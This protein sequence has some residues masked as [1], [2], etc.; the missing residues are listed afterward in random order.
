MSKREIRKAVLENNTFICEKDEK[1]LQEKVGAGAEALG[2]T[3]SSWI[4]GFVTAALCPSTACT[5]DC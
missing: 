4:C 3:T 1:Q 5:G 2:I